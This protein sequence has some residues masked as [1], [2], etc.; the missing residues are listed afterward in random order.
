[1]DSVSLHKLNL[2]KKE[3]PLYT[4]RQFEEGQVGQSIVYEEDEQFVQFPGAKCY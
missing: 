3:S 2:Q 4:G 1:M